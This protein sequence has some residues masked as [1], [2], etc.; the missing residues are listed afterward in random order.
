MEN[1]TKFVESSANTRVLMPLSPKG[2][3]FQ[4]RELAMRNDCCV[5]LLKAYGISNR[6]DALRVATQLRSRGSWEL[7]REV[8]LCYAIVAR[9]RTIFP[10][11][12]GRM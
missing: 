11:D 5:E 4:T 6:E 2:P 3:C 10:N 12:K 7:S 8:I 9:E 1:R